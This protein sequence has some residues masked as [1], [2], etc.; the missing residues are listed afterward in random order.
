MVTGITRVVL[1]FYS[2]PPGLRLVRLD[3][4]Y[5]PPDNQEKNPKLFSQTFIIGD[6]SARII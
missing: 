6:V 2:P 1:L 3:D 5:F 4:Q